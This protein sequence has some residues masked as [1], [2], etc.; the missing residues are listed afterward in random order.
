MRSSECR[1]DEMGQRWLASCA[2]GFMLV[3]LSGQLQ[4]AAAA[5]L[6]IGWKYAWTAWTVAVILAALIPLPWPRR[7]GAPGHGCAWSTPSSASASSLPCWRWPSPDHTRPSATRCLLPNLF[8]TP[9]SRRLARFGSPS[10]P[11]CWTRRHGSRGWLPDR[12]L[13]DL[14]RQGSDDRSVAAV[15]RS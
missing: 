14:A 11:A 9:G 15:V 5:G 8:P 1:E 6:A 12:G 10:P 3:I 2:L 13:S 4:S 7:N